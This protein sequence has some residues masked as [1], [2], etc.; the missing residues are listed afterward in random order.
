MTISKECTS[1]HAAKPLEEFKRH[2]LT[3]DGRTYVCM[4]CLR[5]RPRV[6]LGTPDERRERQ[7]AIL[8][9]RLAT[10][11]DHR[12]RVR[13]SRRKSMFGV[14]AEQAAAILEAQGGVCAIC[15][16]GP[17]GMGGFHV[18]HCHETKRVRGLLCLQCNT[19][20]G[21]LDEDPE[22]LRAAIRYLD[23]ADTGLT[24]AQRARRKHAECGTVSGYMRHRHA[25][26]VACT[27][28]RDAWRDYHRAKRAQQP[29]RKRVAKCGTISGYQSH[30]SRGE[31]PCDA[32]RAA[33]A[34]YQRERKARKAA[35]P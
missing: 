14:T 35:Q 29:S 9:E 30:R 4:D 28:C 18:D 7:L 13:A 11:P 15:G 20:I 16:G 25:E 6:F 21:M 27:A 2:G 32:C 5:A 34:T 26:E 1:C 8:R 33:C 23:E 10:D 31:K 17:S 12:E 3:P 24:V 22:R 19:A